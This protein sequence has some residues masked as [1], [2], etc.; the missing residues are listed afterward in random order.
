MKLLLT[1]QPGVGKTTLLSKLIP[2]FPGAFW[3]TSEEIRNTDGSR[4]GFKAETSTGI[5]AMFA[6]K[7]AIQSDAQIGSFRVDIEAIDRA[8]TNQLKEALRQNWQPLII[9]EIGRMEM[10]SP[11]FVQT[12]DAVFASP[13]HL[14]ATIRQGDDWT[15]R[16]TD[17]SGSILLTL[18]EENRVELGMALESIAAGLNI[19]DQ[20]S[21]PQQQTVVGLARKY[22][23]ADHFIQLKK[24]FKNAIV[25]VVQGRI[26]RLGNAEF[27]VNGLHD[28]H[29]VK[30]KD[31][32]KQCDCDLFSGRNHFASKAGE[33]SH[34]QA[35]MLTLTVHSRV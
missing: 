2:R 29:L 26:E 20:L 10:L 3:V 21:K 8:F 13:M 23:E 1:G 17:H 14:F 34:I 33:C 22:S 16:Y 35:V 30:L 18:T 11:S 19:F 9:D 12:I 24:L 15:G 5:E 28:T 7:T 31:S 25:Y 32:V 4:A 6:H 27:Q